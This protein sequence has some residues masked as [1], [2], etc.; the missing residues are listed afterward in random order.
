LQHHGKNNWRIKILKLKAQFFRLIRE[1]PFY[2]IYFLGDDVE[3]EIKIIIKM[4]SSTKTLE[5][6]IQIEIKE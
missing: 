3:L 1:E 2:F 6:K 4:S 5:P